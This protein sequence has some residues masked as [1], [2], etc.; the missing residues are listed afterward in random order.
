MIPDKLYIP[1][2]TL[3]FNN[4]MSSESISPAGFYS[5]RDFGY[6]RFNKVMPNNLDN[7]IIL[8]DK[9][10]DF[11]INDTE[12]ENY[13]LIIEIETKY[14]AEY[15][16][17]IIQEYKNG[18]FYSEETIYF[19]PLS[20]KLY[21][22]NEREKISTLSKAEP[23]IETKMVALYQNCFCIKPTNIEVFN[24]QMCDLEDSK[25]DFSKH[26]SKDRKINKLKGFL[27][28]YLLGANK[29]LSPEIVNLKKHTKDLRNVLSAVLVSSDNSSYQQKSQIEKFTNAINEAFY[30]AEGLSKIQAIIESKKELYKCENFI[31][32]IKSEGLYDMWF[33]KQNIRPSFQ[34]SQLHLAKSAS[35]DE[36]QEIFDSYFENL[37]T[38]INRYATSTTIKN[39]YLPTLQCFKVNTFP[40][41]SNGINHEFL[42]NLFNEFAQELYNQQVFVESRKDFAF[43][44]GKIFKDALSPKDWEDSEFRKYINGLISNLGNYTSFEINSSN[45]LTLKSFAA[46]CQK[47]EEDIDKLED[48]LISNGIGD[49]RIAFALWGIVFGFANMPK[50]LTN[51]LFLSDDLEYITDVYKCVFKQI[52]GIELEGKIERKQVEHSI[53]TPQV[54]SKPTPRHPTPIDKKPQVDNEEQKFR[55][56][57]KAQKIKQEDEIIEVWKTNGCTVN[58]R[59]FA[60]I[61]KIKCVGEKTIEKIKDCFNY[62]RKILKS[63]S[64]P[65]FPSECSGNFLE[66]YDFLSNNQEFIKLASKEKSWRKDLKWFI[67]EYKN[68]ESKYYGTANE[69][70]AASK[71]NKTVI[72]KFIFLKKGRYKGTESFLKSLYLSND[73]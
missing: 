28:A 19:S 44:G 38:T 18:V 4:L 21:F 43:S 69:K 55:Q 54:A 72:Q 32:I 20:T 12:I 58:D 40:K 49:F 42:S 30:K 46:F 63:G 8:Y 53:C 7:R 27:Y 52:H 11:K 16:S 45:N 29:S 2:T 31:D 71:D 56:N 3:N 70:G 64:T 23:S 10:P 73:R 57:L 15:V 48:Y 9:Y 47:G 36:K 14:I 59:L 33:Q 34:L 17:D 6:K 68:S 5:V 50:T 37:D 61:L 22:A 66:D 35:P 24:L 65:M 51:E 25:S 60:D 41:F 13:P 67:S 1:T 39:E 26:I 62:Q